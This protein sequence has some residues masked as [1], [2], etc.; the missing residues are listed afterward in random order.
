MSVQALTGE[1]LSQSGVTGTA[2]LVEVSPAISFA[3]AFSSTASS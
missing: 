3:S 1:A 2:M